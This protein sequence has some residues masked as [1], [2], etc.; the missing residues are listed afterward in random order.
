M[1][2]E[3][4]STTSGS[5]FATPVRPTADTSALYGEHDFEQCAPPDEKARRQ[6]K[7]DRA[8]RRDGNRSFAN[9]NRHGHRI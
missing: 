3:L 9:P 5:T 4:T 2:P 7:A 8:M 1:S 6:A